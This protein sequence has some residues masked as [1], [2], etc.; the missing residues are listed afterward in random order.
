MM[1]KYPIVARYNEI[2]E[3]LLISDFLEKFSKQNFTDSEMLLALTSVS[4]WKKAVDDDLLNDDLT[5]NHQTIEIHIQFQ[6]LKNL[7]IISLDGVSLNE[8]EILGNLYNFHKESNPAVAKESE[9]LI[10][11]LAKDYFTILK[12]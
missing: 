6:T 3:S 8:A 5:K 11:K 4:E 7:G 10:A 12:K 9:V 2:L 1:T